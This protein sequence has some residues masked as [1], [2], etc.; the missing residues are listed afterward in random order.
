M[1]T[2]R[3]LFITAQW[4]GIIILFAIG[5]YLDNVG[6]A[7]LCLPF[8]FAFITHVRI[9]DDLVEDTKIARR[10]CVEEWEATANAKETAE[11]YKRALQMQR[12][13]FNDG[14]VDEYICYMTTH[15]SPSLVEMKIFQGFINRKD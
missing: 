12:D 13:G 4:L 11:I 10:K 5:I 8:L 7:L 9:V 3:I 2:E 6:I 14:V 1:K 15:R